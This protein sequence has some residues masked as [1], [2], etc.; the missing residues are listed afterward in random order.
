MSF[1]LSSLPKIHTPSL[2]NIFAEREGKLRL[3][4]RGLGGGVHP[5]KRRLM[6]VFREKSREGAIARKGLP[7]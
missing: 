2:L 1:I 7:P 6:E 3:A 4:E 5:Q